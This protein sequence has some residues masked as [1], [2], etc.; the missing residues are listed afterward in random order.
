[1]AKILT[2][3]GAQRNFKEAIEAAYDVE[4]EVVK[5]EG[6]RSMRQSSHYWLNILNSVS[7]ILS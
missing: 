4:F 7:A 1:M 3:Q 5:D 2:D 6:E